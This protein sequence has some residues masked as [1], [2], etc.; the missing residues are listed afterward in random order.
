M[1]NQ[2]QLV[3]LIISTASHSYVVLPEYTRYDNLHARD[4]TPEHFSF[5]RHKQYEK[6]QLL[7]SISV[8]LHSKNHGNDVE[9]KKRKTAKAEKLNGHLSKSYTLTHSAQFSSH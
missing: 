5:T 9:G 7:K 8:I 3:L 2:K 1:N 4:T 6:W